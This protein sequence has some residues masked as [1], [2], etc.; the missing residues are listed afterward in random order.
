MDQQALFHVNLEEALRT[1]VDA[2]GGPKKVS[3]RMWP[4][5]ATSHQYLLHC[6][7]PEH[8]QK[9]SQHELCL[10]MKWGREA[11]CHAAMQFLAAECGYE[12]PRP[13]EPEDEYARLQREF[14]RRADELKN[15]GEAIRRTQAQVQLKAVS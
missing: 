3:E 13:I 4:N 7:N 12:N 14:I 6:L 1:V 8:D 11:K 2:L 9:L 10:L 15:L 5:K